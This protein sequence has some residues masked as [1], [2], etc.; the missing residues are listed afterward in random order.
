MIPSPIGTGSVEPSVSQPLSTPS[1]VAEVFA[2][3]PKPPSI[4]RDAYEPKNH[5][6]SISWWKPDCTYVIWV[7]VP[8]ANAAVQYHPLQHLGT[9]FPCVGGAGAKFML[10]REE[11]ILF[12]VRWFVRWFIAVSVVSEIQE[13]NIVCPV[14]GIAA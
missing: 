13:V 8:H 2:N 7:G 12:I 5:V 10:D 14:Q 11:N 9:E 3:I 1:M 6:D 4:V